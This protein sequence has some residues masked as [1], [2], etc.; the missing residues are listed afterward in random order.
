MKVVHLED[1]HM[2]TVSILPIMA[3]TDQ[4]KR[5]NIMAALFGKPSPD[6]PV[7]LER[8][9][10]LRGDEK[11]RVAALVVRNA[12]KNPKRYE[13]DAAKTLLREAT[14]LTNHRH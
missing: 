8:F 6:Y 13:E 7:M 9:R 5:E 12:R 11:T 2:S 10:A 3:H 4:A 14:S 1:L